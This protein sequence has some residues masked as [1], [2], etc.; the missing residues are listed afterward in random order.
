M[1]FI[2]ASITN[3]EINKTTTS[4]L[5]D[6]DKYWNN[7]FFVIVEIY[8]CTQVFIR[9]FLIL[10][11]LPRL[12]KLYCIDSAGW[13]KVF[14]VPPT[15]FLLFSN[16]LG[17]LH[18]ISALRSYHIL[19]PN[20]GFFNPRV[21]HRVAWDTYFGYSSIWWLR[22]SK[23]VSIHLLNGGARL[24]WHLTLSIHNFLCQL[25]KILQFQVVVF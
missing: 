14:L 17:G 13:D 22:T 2:L 1:Y 18:I 15:V 8:D 23:T 16:F 19:S 3:V 24:E 11:H 4:F 21:F 12:S 6:W 20:L 10:F 9:K 5:V 25:L 7:C